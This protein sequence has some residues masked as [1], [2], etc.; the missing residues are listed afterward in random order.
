MPDLDVYRDW[1]GIK[2]T[3][4]PLDFYQLLR[5]ERFE[6]NID[7]IRRHYR[8]LN[9]HTRKYSTGKYAELS[10]QVL[11]ELARAMLCLTD[12][13]RKADYD[14]SLGRQKAASGRRQ[15]FEDLLVAQGAV[16]RESLEKAQKFASATG[17][18]IR[19][20]VL[21]QKLATP[22]IVMQEYAESLGLPYLDLGDVTIDPDLLRRIS[23][24]TA[25]TYSFVPVMVDDDQL[26]L[27]SPNP[28]SL[29]VEEDIRSRVGMPI[30]MVLCTPADVNR[31]INQHYTK[32]A[33]AEEV[34][35]RTA[36][37]KKEEPSGLSKFWSKM[38]DLGKMDLGG[39]KK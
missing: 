1:L 31:L 32:E 23:A 20:A 24:V 35:S 9:A 39:G 26:L 2:E 29:D 4:R 28:L 34:H 13:K 25:R 30:R 38:K 16:N 33:A 21:Q 17:M 12:A 7:R 8:K 15:T 19:D 11:N 3:A 18:S 5:L 14:A 27:A 36:A 37:P 22:E 6:D 10:Q